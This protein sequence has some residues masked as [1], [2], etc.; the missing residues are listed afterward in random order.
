[1]R[2]AA[3]G[4]PHTSNPPSART[5]RCVED[6][7]LRVLRF[8]GADPS[9]Y[10]LIWTR[11]ATGALHLLGEAFPWTED[12]VFAYLTSNH[13]SVLGESLP[14]Q[15]LLSPLLL[16]SLLSRSP[17]CWRLWRTVLWLASRGFGALCDARG[18]QLAGR[19]DRAPPLV[20][21]P[22]PSAGIREYA[23]QYGAAFGAVDELDAEAW[24]ASK[25]QLPKA[26][27]RAGGRAG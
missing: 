23:R 4:N 5:Q 16:L 25:A 22:G 18:G 17:L 6:T 2:T 1:M 7:R 19:P 12:S 8:F 24:F 11:S 3:L 21:S 9:M 14:S 13:N 26:S 10:Q 27:G 20:R 15:L